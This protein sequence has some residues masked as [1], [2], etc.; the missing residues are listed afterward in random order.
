MATIEEEIKATFAKKFVKSDSHLFKTMAEFHLRRATSLR[1][2]DVAYVPKP[3]RLLVRNVQKRL[4]IG[5]GTELLLKALYL[6]HGFCI[7]KLDA[8]PPL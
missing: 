1:Q 8:K 2:V 5:I 3:Y 6:K 7:N 4:L